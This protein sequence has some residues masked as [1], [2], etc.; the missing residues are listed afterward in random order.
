MLLSQKD[1]LNI[2]IKIKIQ[3][4]F[5]TKSKMKLPLA[6]ASNHSSTG[7]C[8][9]EIKQDPFDAKNNCWI[10]S[11]RVT[12]H[13]RIQRSLLSR[14]SILIRIHVN[15]SINRI[16][17]SSLCSRWT[18]SSSRWN[19]RFAGTIQSIAKS[20]MTTI[21]VRLL[22]LLSPRGSLVSCADYANLRGN[23]VEKR[24][25]GDEGTGATED[26]FG[27]LSLI[28]S[29]VCLFLVDLDL[30]L[31]PE[32]TTAEKSRRVYSMKLLFYRSTLI[33]FLM[34]WICIDER[35]MHGLKKIVDE[36]LNVKH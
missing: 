12:F 7:N 22:D 24:T 21:L 31:F 26:S 6:I 3:S 27:A 9:R 14:E 1:L 4:R 33:C 2:Y 25:R 15:K 36:T 20:R 17:D 35:S 16:L 23:P 34:S 30:L 32:I 29:C 18:I 13:S 28:R 19:W 5:K 8:N 10:V 11:L